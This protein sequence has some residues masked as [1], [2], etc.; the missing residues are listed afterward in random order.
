MQRRRHQPEQGERRVAPAD[1]R[2]R[3][4]YC[5][6]LLCAGQVGERRAGVCNRDEVEGWRNLGHRRVEGIRLGRRAGLRRHAEQCA[7]AASP[8]AESTHHVGMRRVQDAQLRAL[9]RRDVEDAAEE[10]RGERRTPHS[11]HSGAPIPIAQDVVAQVRQLPNATRHGRGKVEPAHP[12]G[13]RIGRV[14]GGGPQRAILGPNPLSHA[15]GLPGA[16][17]LI[18]CVLQPVGR[19]RTLARRVAAGGAGVGH[20]GA[21]A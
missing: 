1:I 7:G 19:H 3:F 9:I 14:A 5:A 17:P 2:R 4:E 10:L 20:A 15:I 16:K 18:D 8:F 13:Q 21:S 6:E 11:Q 12:G